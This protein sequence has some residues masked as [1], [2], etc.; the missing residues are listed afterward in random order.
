MA[1][2]V[3]LILVEI[4]LVESGPVFV[5]LSAAANPVKPNTAIMTVEIAEAARCHMTDDV[6]VVCIVPS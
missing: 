4:L 1:L 6:V 3:L 5:I 2:Q